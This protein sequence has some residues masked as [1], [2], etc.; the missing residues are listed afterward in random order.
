M[1]SEYMITYFEF[2]TFGFDIGILETLRNYIAPGGYYN[3]LTIANIE[4]LE[5]LKETI[6]KHFEESKTAFK[7]I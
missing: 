7:L 3:P 6:K 5:A 4:K 2:K 1:N